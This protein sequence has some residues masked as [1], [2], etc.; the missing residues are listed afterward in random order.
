MVV[1]VEEV[2]VE[3]G[4]DE[5]TNM[6]K[7]IFWF[8]CVLIFGDLL[9]GGVYYA[10]SGDYWRHQ[11]MPILAIEGAGFTLGFSLLIFV[12]YFTA[13]YILKRIIIDLGSFYKNI[14]IKLLLLA[15]VLYAIGFG[16]MLVNKITF[17]IRQKEFR[18]NQKVV[19][20]NFDGDVLIRNLVAKPVPQNY[21]L[22]EVGY[23]V[24]IPSKYIGDSQGTIYLKVGNDSEL[25]KIESFIN[26]YKQTV[27][28][29]DEWVVA[30]NA[31]RINPKFL[32]NGDLL[33]DVIYYKNEIDNPDYKNHKVEFYLKIEPRSTGGQNLIYHELEL[34]K[35][36]YVR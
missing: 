30:N 18:E 8:L 2:G 36:F 34:N 24:L 9:L 10:L 20:N 29:N 17:N 16:H 28:E 25:Y 14:V 33:I 21:R 22:Y 32:S 7:F 6:K 13:I 19:Q 12:P 3:E 27:T 5:T 11:P 1:V 15:F 35:N 26:Y 4:R 31:S 23:E